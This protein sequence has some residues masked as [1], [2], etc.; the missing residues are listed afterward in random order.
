MRNRFKILIIFFLLIFGWAINV[1]QAKRYFPN[2]IHSDEP[3]WAAYSYLTF[4][5]IAVQG[6]IHHDVWLLAHPHTGMTPAT[7]KFIIGAYLYANGINAWNP[8]IALY[9]N[10]HTMEWN[11]VHGF[12]PDFESIRSGRKLI[13]FFGVGVCLFVG[14]ILSRI[15]IS[16]SWT[17]PLLL[18]F[19]PLFSYLSSHVLMDMIALFFSCFSF[20]AFLRAD[21]S[22]VEGK[23]N[24]KTV[25]FSILS[26]IALATAVGTKM[27][28]LLTAFF[29]IAVFLLICIRKLLAVGC[30]KETDHLDP[31]I[32]LLIWL[33]SSIFF[34]L[35]NPG[36]YSDPTR[37]IALFL[38]LGE[39]HTNE[40]RTLYPALAL[41][42]F[43]DKTQAVF[44]VAFKDYGFF[45]NT[46]LI[47][48]PLIIAGIYALFAKCRSKNSIQARASIPIGIFLFIIIF[49][50]GLWLPLRFERYF[51][52]FV[53]CFLIL[54]AL[55]IDDVIKFFQGLWK[56][57][58]PLRPC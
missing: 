50:N 51:L 17:A 30:K 25:L 2:D 22:C 36:F 45:N 9:D 41:R 32:F 46:F 34:I 13:A 37:T 58:E 8:K 20:W 7:G 28:E 3:N 40:M 10:K 43:G 52:P 57:S 19:H 23:S 33:S 12:L 53:F 48:I 24:R 47:E 18:F 26:G 15:S 5:L 27:R 56:P 6:K 16:A 21:E 29:F 38:N 39:F 54:E 35:T 55:A 42:T 49:G 44:E 11:K 31:I 14:L 1:S 4:Y